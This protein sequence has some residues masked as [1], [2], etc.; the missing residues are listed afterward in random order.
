MKSEKWWVRYW[1]AT[2]HG[3]LF[4]AIILSAS[5]ALTLEIWPDA[6]SH[7]KALAALG[8]LVGSL[9]AAGRFQNKWRSNRLTLSRLTQLDL[10]LLNPNADAAST[11]AELQ[12]IR[13]DHDKEIVGPS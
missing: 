7:A 1:S 3:C 6:S 13:D 2:Y 11:L 9:A 10:A 4:G 5:A 8:A 12:K